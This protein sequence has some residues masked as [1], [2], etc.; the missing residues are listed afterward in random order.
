MVIWNWDVPIE[1][2]LG[3]IQS[4]GAQVGAEKIVEW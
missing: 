3:C 4:P 1:D 2:I